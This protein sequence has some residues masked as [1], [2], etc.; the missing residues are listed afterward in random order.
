[1]TASDHPLTHHQPHA[2]GWCSAWPARGVFTVTRSLLKLISAL[3]SAFWL[4]AHSDVVMS[5]L[6]TV[7]PLKQAVKVL[8]EQCEQYRAEAAKAVSDALWCRRELARHRQSTVFLGGSAY[9][10]RHLRAVPSAD[11]PAA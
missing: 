7:P 5:E 8:T 1:M 4:L 10:G 2:L 9:R 6:R 11:E 3:T